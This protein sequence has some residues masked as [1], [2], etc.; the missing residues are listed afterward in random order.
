MLTGSKFILAYKNVLQK[1][2]VI[3]AWTVSTDNSKTVLTQTGKS[4]NWGDTF[5]NTNEITAYYYK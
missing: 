3:S 5:N 1:S 2:D 4:G